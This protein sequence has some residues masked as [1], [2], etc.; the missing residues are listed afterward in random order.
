MSLLIVHV[1]SFSLPLS[2]ISLFIERCLRNQTSALR[3]TSRGN[4]LLS[5][6]PNEHFGA[7]LSK[8]ECSRLAL[9]RNSVDSSQTFN[10]TDIT[11]PLHIT[12][13]HTIQNPWVNKFWDFL[14]LDKAPPQH[15]SAWVA[16]RSS[17]LLLRESR[18]ISGVLSFH[19]EAVSKAEAMRGQIEARRPPKL[20]LR[21]P[22]PS[23]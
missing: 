21:I 15:S 4:G 19:P 3:V 23:L 20:A 2:A 10:I 14:R 6:C 18:M 11:W 12:I 8:T 22:S 9:S 13:I 1:L 7:F 16:L 5:G 17:G